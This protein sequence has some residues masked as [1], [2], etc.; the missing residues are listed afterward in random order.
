MI[1]NNTNTK[2]NNT[3]RTYRKMR[4]H[5]RKGLG[6]RVYTSYLSQCKKIIFLHLGQ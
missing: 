5:D 4:V 6:C 2:I 3:D 1:P